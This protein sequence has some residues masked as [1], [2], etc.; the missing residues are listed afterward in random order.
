MSIICVLT[1]TAPLATGVEHGDGNQASHWKYR[2]KNKFGIMDP[3]GHFGEGSPITSND[4]IALDVIGWDAVP[5]P[6]AAYL[7]GGGLLA[8]AL[9]RHRKME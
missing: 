9:I 4:L 2:R 5:E 8:L 3:S 7:L 1:N 6:S